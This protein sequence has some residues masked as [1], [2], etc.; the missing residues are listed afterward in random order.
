MNLCW[1]DCYWTKDGDQDNRG[2]TYYCFSWSVSPT[3]DERPCCRTLISQQVAHRHATS[4][5]FHISGWK[6]RVEYK[7]ETACCTR[8]GNAGKCLLWAKEG[9]IH[10]VKTAANTVQLVVEPWLSPMFACIFSSS[11]SSHYPN[12]SVTHTALC[13]QLNLC[14]KRKKN[15]FC[16]LLCLCFMKF[17]FEIVLQNCYI[18]VW[19]Y[20]LLE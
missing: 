12:S 13:S 7:L 16:K 1:L 4:Y 20:F 8:F 11:L 9:T 5:G 10:S 6:G 15:N 18:S 3:P 19:M 14:I 17:L 2:H